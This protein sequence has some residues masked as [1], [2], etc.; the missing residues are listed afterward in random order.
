MFSAPRLYAISSRQT[1]PGQDLAA[2]LERL[3]DGPA[4][5]IQWREKDL[6]PDACL[7]WIRLGNRL[8]LERGKSFLVNSDF[9]TALREGC[10]GVH[11]TSRQSPGPALRR[12]REAGRSDFVVGQSTHS[13]EEA[14]RAEAAGVDYVMLG[15]VFA[16]LSKTSDLPPL[17]LA[18][19]AEACRRLRIPVA[20]VGGVQGER[21]RQVFEAGAWA[22]AGI[23]WAAQLP[24]GS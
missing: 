13:L 17:G 11:L 18:A 2:Y 6:S 7:P 12:R 16:P 10:S 22:A 20:A 23:T 8:A 3:V 4:E 24:L 19:L 1:L 15:P 9:E 14:L 21:V 5:V